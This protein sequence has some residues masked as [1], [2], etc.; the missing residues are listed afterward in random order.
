VSIQRAEKMHTRTSQEQLHNHRARSRDLCVQSSC[1][2]GAA[3]TGGVAQQIVM[4]FEGIDPCP[5]ATHTCKNAI[6][7]DEFFQLFS[8]P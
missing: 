6:N 8:L 3:S 5:T 2:S 4:Q 1:S 7:I